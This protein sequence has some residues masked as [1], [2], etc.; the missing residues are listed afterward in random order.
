MPSNWIE[1]YRAMPADLKVETLARTWDACTSAERDLIV[2][3]LR[4]VSA[5]TPP[6]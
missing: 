4:H 3:D 5:S 6:A 1:F 2:A